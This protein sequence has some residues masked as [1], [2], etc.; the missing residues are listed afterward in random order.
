MAIVS[1]SAAQYTSLCKTNRDVNNVK[2]MLFLLVY[3]THGLTHRK[4]IQKAHINKLMQRRYSPVLGVTYFN[5]RMH[6]GVARGSDR[7]LRLE[8]EL[9]V[10]LQ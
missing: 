10:K 4:L 9:E 7:G 2:M 5:A 6:Q 1:T 8:S 3:S